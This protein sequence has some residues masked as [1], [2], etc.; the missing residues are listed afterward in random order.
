M[1]VDS[2]PDPS[3]FSFP[4]AAPV[5]SVGLPSCWTARGSSRQQQ[6]QQQQ[7]AGQAASGG[8]SQ[9]SLQLDLSMASMAASQSTPAQQQQQ[10]QQQHINEWQHW[11]PAHPQDGPLSDA[12]N[13]HP[14]AADGASQQP[15][16]LPPG[17]KRHAPFGEQPAGPGAGEPAAKRAHQAA[18]D[19]SCHEQQ[20]QQV[21]P[22]RQV[23]GAGGEGRA[24]ISEDAVLRALEEC[25]GAAAAPDLARRLGCAPG[26]GRERRL[27]AVLSGLVGEAV[28]MRGPRASSADALQVL[29]DPDTQ[30]CLL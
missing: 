26:E 15:D 3:T 11:A 30:F 24:G 28:Y 12:S 27:A 21:Q 7:Q 1:P 6:Q 10:Q 23:W 5:G 4:D 16:R 17:G 29:W 25:G 19:G 8:G 20:Q 22:Q 13:L 18:A 2:Q 9:G 14:A